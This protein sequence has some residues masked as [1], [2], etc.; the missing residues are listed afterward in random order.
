MSYSLSPQKTKRTNK[1]QTHPQTVLALLFLFAVC[2][3]A[4]LCVPAGAALV[5]DVL[6]GS[7][8]TTQV[9]GAEVAY[10]VVITGIPSQ[11]ASLELST[12][13]MPVTDAPLWKS[14]TE[15]VTVDSPNERLIHLSAEGEF[16]VSVTLE[17]TGR[18]PTISTTK[19]VDGVVIKKIASQRS[20]YLYYD[21]KALDAQDKSL[22]VASTGTLTIEVADEQSFLTRAE[23]VD[24]TK[25]RNLLTEFYAKGLTAEAWELLEWYEATP[26]PMPVFVPVIVGV[27]VLLLGLAAGVVVGMKSA[28]RKLNNDEEVF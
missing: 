19:T 1:K 18:V 14:G 28:Y 11:A 13:L 15:G 27:T 5:T 2:V 10:T 23:A 24:D 3:V 8:P 7:L 17:M 9:E 6:G 12:D 20:G 4:T 26:T 25:F 16:P 22:G 21:V